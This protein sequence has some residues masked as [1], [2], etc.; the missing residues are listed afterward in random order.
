VIQ[1]DQSDHQ[2]HSDPKTAATTNE[3]MALE[4][5]LDRGGFVWSADTVMSVVQLRL[6]PNW[7]LKPDFIFST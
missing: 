7:A 6:Y 3:K 2:Y 4:S 1:S 5:E